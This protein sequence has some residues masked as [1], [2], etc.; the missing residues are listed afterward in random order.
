MAKYIAEMNGN[1][2]CKKTVKFLSDYLSVT[3]DSA[4]TIKSNNIIFEYQF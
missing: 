4:N 2:I 3:H 1:V